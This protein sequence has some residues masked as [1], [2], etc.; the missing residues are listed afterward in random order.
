MNA[1]EIFLKMKEDNLKNEVNLA[2]KINDGNENLKNSLSKIKKNM[3][4]VSIY[5]NVNYD[6]FSKKLK[7]ESNNNYPTT[8]NLYKIN[9]NI[10][11]DKTRNTR[12]SYH[13]DFNSNE[14]IR[15][16]QIIDE[17]ITIL[18]INIDEKNKINNEKEVLYLKN[19]LMNNNI[20]RI[21]NNIKNINKKDN[22]EIKKKIETKKKENKIDIKN[23]NITNNLSNKNNVD[24]NINHK[25]TISNSLN[26][27]ESTL[28][29]TN[30]NNS[31]KTINKQNNI[32]QNQK[33]LNPK[34]IQL[35]TFFQ[36]Q[37]LH[38]S[39]SLL[40]KTRISNNKKKNKNINLTNSTTLQSNSKKKNSNSKTINYDNDINEQYKKTISIDSNK[41]NYD[42]DSQNKIVSKY[43]TRRS[44]KN[45]L[46]NIPSKDYNNYY[47]VCINSVKV[48]DCF[49]NY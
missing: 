29:K 41:K 16:I 26:L 22:K 1:K 4:K 48:N 28:N 15:E 10:I 40:L 13:E 11:S 37:N 24:K 46:T 3:E 25:K 18:D 30:K 45:Y 5:S 2:K 35:K 17:P 8:E 7:Y 21:N 19:E 34:T 32:I 31:K 49:I 12:N 36:N 33:K 38:K 6:C 39:P 43:N 44:D 42:I 27:N 14:N 47:L 20:T 9:D 23:N